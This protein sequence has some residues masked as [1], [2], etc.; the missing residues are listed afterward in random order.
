MLIC[1]KCKVSQN[2]S[3][4]S[5]NARMK[6][7][8]NLWCKKCFA[9][10]QQSPK[11][12]EGKRRYNQSE[13]GRAHIRQYRIENTE[14]IRVCKALFRTKYPVWC[15]ASS[16][17]TNIRNRS[18]K[19][20]IPLD[21][22]KQNLIDMQN[23]S[24]T[25]PCCFEPF[26]FNLNGPNDPHSPSVDRIIPELGYVKSNVKMI[27]LGCNRQKNDSSIEQLEQVIR[28]MKKHQELIV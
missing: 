19:Y 22:T 26:D 25:C 10:Y 16:T 23:E 13:K 27:C 8:Y 2:E 21:I 14:K 6:S 18:K 11:Y 4:F 9:V 3:G 28:Y 15:R 24:D 17:L 20:S 7:G 12:K 1:G 5:R